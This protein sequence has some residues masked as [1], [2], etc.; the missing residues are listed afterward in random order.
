MKRI[1]AVIDRKTFYLDE[2]HNPSV[3]GYMNKKCTATCGPVVIRYFTHEF[4]KY[5]TIISV[6]KLINIYCELS[7]T[8][9]PFAV[10]NSISFE[11]RNVTIRVIYLAKPDLVE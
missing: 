6:M 4:I 5:R 2:L 1:C 8:Q 9:Q 11:F 10:V 3:C 7:F